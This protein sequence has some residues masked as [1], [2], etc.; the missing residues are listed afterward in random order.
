MVPPEQEEEEEEEEVEEE[1]EGK[2]EEMGRERGRGRRGVGGR[3]WEEEK[4]EERKIFYI[5][6]WVFSVGV[7]Y[8]LLTMCASIS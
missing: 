2:G 5:A 8:F 6:S 7:S 4:G 1:E 3:G